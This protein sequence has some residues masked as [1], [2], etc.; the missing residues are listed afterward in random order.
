AEHFVKR[1]GDREDEEEQHDE[2]ADPHADPDPEDAR[3]LEVFARWHTCHGRRRPRVQAGAGAVEKALLRP[4]A[5]TGRP[6][7]MM[8]SKSLPA[9]SVPY[10]RPPSRFRREAQNASATAAGAL[11]TSSEPCRHS[12]MPSTTRP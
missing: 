8:P 2:P 1:L 3:E 4:Q 5:A 7:A 10:S 9:G 12:A 6:R 11:R